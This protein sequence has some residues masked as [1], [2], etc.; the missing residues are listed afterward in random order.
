MTNTTAE[1]TE[2]EAQEQAAFDEQ[3]EAYITTSDAIRDPD[4]D[5]YASSLDTNNR[6]AWELDTPTHFA[7]ATPNWNDE[8]GSNTEMWERC[9]E[10]GDELRR[11]GAGQKPGRDTLT[12]NQKLLDNSFSEKIKQHIV[13]PHQ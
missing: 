4:R 12:E 9:G 5:R 13:T 3:T 7:W 1:I 2:Q 8:V 11:R 10:V 6:D